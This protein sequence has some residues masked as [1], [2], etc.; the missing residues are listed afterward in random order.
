MSLDE[1][2]SVLYLGNDLS[3]QPS[4]CHG[5][6]PSIVQCIALMTNWFMDSFEGGKWGIQ[7]R[8]VCNNSGTYNVSDINPLVDIDPESCKKY[9]KDMANELNKM[10]KHHTMYTQQ[11]HSF[12][13]D[14]YIM[15]RLP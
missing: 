2:S 14:S 13:H 1:L 11:L 6:S 7:S 15:V 3:K 4:D 8:C 10:W 12:K 9:S 5:T